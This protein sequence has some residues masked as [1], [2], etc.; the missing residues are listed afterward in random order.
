M[1]LKDDF[2]IVISRADALGDMVLTLPMAGLLKSYFPGCKIYYLAKK[3]AEPLIALSSHIDGF[4]EYDYLSGLPRQEQVLYLKKFEA[5][6]FV[7]VLPDRGLAFLARE[8]GIP[9]RAG[10]TNRWYHWLTCNRLIRLSRKR[11]D[12]HEAQLNIRLLKFLPVDTHVPL[13]RIQEYYGI[14]KPPS[15]T[16][17][18]LPENRKKIVLLHPRSNGSG[19]EWSIDNYDRLIGLLDP[20]VYNVVVCGLPREADSIAPLFKRHPRAINAIGQVTL[21][22]YIQLICQSHALVASGTGPLHIAAMMGIKTIGLFPRRK[23]VGPERWQP[24]GENACYLTSEGSCSCAQQPG[25]N[26]MDL[27]PAEKVAAYIEGNP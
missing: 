26:C 11:S 9:L 23:A 18:F 17:A 24:L 6:I 7:N 20:A 4:I 10:T 2:T 22:E 13:R 15:G 1:P 25:C 8:A 27:I 21:P 14:R 3:Y 5:D 19:R 12:L 16:F